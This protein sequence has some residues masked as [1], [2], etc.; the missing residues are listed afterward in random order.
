VPPLP[1]ARRL[2]I[3]LSLLVFGSSTVAGLAACSDV[4][5]DASASA[6]ASIAACEVPDAAID[7]E[8]AAAGRAMAMQNHC[9]G[10]HQAVP[11]DAGG[12]T[13]SGKSRQTNLTPDP[14]TGIGCWPEDAV[15][16][17]ILD[18]VS[19]DGGPLCG[20]PHFRTK[21]VE[22]GVD[23][24]AQAQALA[25]FLRSLEVVVSKPEAGAG[26]CP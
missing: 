23:P 12:L 16:Q 10:C 2:L 26:S 11:V 20:M 9:Y 15:E 19:P 8:M 24:A 25:A 14:E 17:A 5:T 13:L 3:S 7:P 21:W 18:G 1:G 4:A 6:P 22:A